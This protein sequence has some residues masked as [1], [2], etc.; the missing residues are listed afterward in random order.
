LE[1]LGGKVEGSFEDRYKKLC[2][3]MNQKENKHISRL[4][5][6]ALY[7][8]IRNKLDHASDSNRVTPEEAIRI[9]E[10]VKDFIHEV[11]PSIDRS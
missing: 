7:K 10:I 4:L 6:S 1:K 3:L 9:S 5:P 8:G 2:E 11:F